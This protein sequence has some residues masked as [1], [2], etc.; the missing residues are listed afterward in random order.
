MYVLLQVGPNWALFNI[1]SLYW[2]VVGDATNAIECLRRAL[3]YAPDPARDVGLIGMANVLH[4]LGALEEAVIAARAAL[5]IKT[6]SVG[7]ELLINT[8]YF[9]SVL[10]TFTKCNYI[11]YFTS[12]LAIFTKCNYIQ[13]FTSVSATFTKCKIS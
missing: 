2:R 12:V 10:A 8:Q 1:A 13:Y 9:T 3:Y 5:D 6:E 7:V 4:G 11:Q